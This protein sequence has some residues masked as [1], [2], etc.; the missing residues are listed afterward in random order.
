MFEPSLIAMSTLFYYMLIYSRESKSC[1]ERTCR[2]WCFS[3]RPVIELFATLTVVV[4]RFKFGSRGSFISAMAIAL[5]CSSVS[6]LTVINREVMSAPT[7][8]VDFVDESFEFSLKATSLFC[9]SVATIFAWTS[10]LHHCIRSKA[11][12]TIFVAGLVGKST[13]SVAPTLEF[14]VS[15]DLLMTIY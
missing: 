4:I 7:M 15:S 3:Y 1:F 5:V 8:A 6:T 12:K 11:F 14:L 2:T 9:A 10:H 13:Y